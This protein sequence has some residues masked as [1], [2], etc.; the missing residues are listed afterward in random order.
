M[1]RDSNMAD[2]WTSVSGYDKGDLL[3]ISSINGIANCEAR[4]TC[5]GTLLG[6]NNN[7][8]VTDGE[9]A[10]NKPFELDGS[11]SFVVDK[12][13]ARKYKFSTGDTVVLSLPVKTFLAAISNGG[14]P[15]EFKKLAAALT[16]NVKDGEEN[17]LSSD[18]IRFPLSLPA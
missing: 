5:S 11:L 2:I 18:Y 6:I 7:L 9:P 10:I 17:I 4:Y 13:M 8:I 1:Y 16:M 12:N 3:H 15:D 14:N